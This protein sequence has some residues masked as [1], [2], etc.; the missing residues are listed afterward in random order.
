MALEATAL[1]KELIKIA[2]LEPKTFRHRDSCTH[3]HCATTPVQKIIFNI[4]N[5]V[6]NVTGE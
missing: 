2:G 1:H 3:D 5:V 4:V 6:V